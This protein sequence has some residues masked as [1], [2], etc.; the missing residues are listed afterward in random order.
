MLV[1]KVLLLIF[2]ILVGLTV[3]L[4]WYATHFKAYAPLAPV[5]YP[6]T[7]YT[8]AKYGFSISYPVS[9]ALREFP[10]SPTGGGFRPSDK[11]NDPQYEV[12]TVNVIPKVSDIP[13]DEY[14]KTA[15]AQEIQNYTHL[16]SLGEIHTTSGLLGYT[17]TWQVTSPAVFGLQP[18]PKTFISLPITYFD[19]PKSNPPATVQVWISD[20]S[21][22]RQYEVMIKSFTLT[23]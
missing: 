9:L 23:E 5:L 6:L 19:L 13:F 18:K 17:T 3:G 15:A 8:N 1:R 21:Y 20:P 14:V 4:V 12:I 22:M 10:D 2:F 11:P 16:D 7:T